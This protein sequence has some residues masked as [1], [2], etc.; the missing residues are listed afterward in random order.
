VSPHGLH[1][2][3]ISHRSI[4]SSTLF[5]L[6]G[7]V[8]AKQQYLT[9]EQSSSASE[10]SRD[11]AAM[12]S[13][14]RKYVSA[15]L[16]QL[17]AEVSPDTVSRPVSIQAPSITKRPVALQGPFLLQPSPRLLS[18][19]DVPD[20]SDITYLTCGTPDTT[21]EDGGLERLGLVLIAQHD[22]RVDICL[23][24]EKVEA[25]WETSEV[26]TLEVTA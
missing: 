18:T 10:P 13:K 2:T 16:Q 14:Q 12:Y 3:Y 7:Y 26:R 15:L 11:V 17:P 20:A 24:L 21:A 25:R 5:A 19:M 1:R 4:P 23:D 8:S 6:E 22:G 9:A